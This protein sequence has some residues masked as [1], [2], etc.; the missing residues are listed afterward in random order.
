ME[1]IKNEY[2]NGKSIKLIAED[3][4]VGFDAISSRL[5]KMGIFKY[6][7]R[8]WTNDEISFLKENYSTTDWDIIL[9]YL[10]RWEKPEIISKA[11]RLNLTRETFFWNETDLEI[12]RQNYSD[13][14]P[15]KE[16]EKN[17]NYKFTQTAI[18]TKAYTLGLYQRNW[19]T[20]EENQKLKE[21]YHSYDMDEICKIFPNRSKDS[22][23]A[24][25]IKLGLSY[26]TVWTD[27]ELQFLKDNH[28]SMTDEEIGNKLGRSKD[29]IRGKR[30][31][32]KLYHPIEPR[33]YNY[34]SE[35][36]RKRNKEWKKKSAKHCNYKCVITGE[37]FQEIHHLYGMNKII[38]ETLSDLNY[39]ENTDIS[40][41]TQ[42]DLDVILNHFYE[43]QD[44]YSLG[45]CLTKEIHKQFHNI[46]G[47]GDNTSE[48]F[49]EFILSHNY[50]LNI[51]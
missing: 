33:V 25:A 40:N 18:L 32:E 17:L 5:K 13:K 34:L 41:L 12:L 29:S 46:Y 16:I 37:R 8:H 39:P 48:Q 19:W 26:K 45:I 4:N 49:D 10:S 11:S 38:Q 47:Y 9:K 7:T 50:S 28:R 30:F 51:A 3:F 24:H 14:I 27:D 22:I 1:Y 23:I 20:D 31:V 15:V 44:K 42:N 43:V 2:L 36:I 35:Y 6:K 21:I